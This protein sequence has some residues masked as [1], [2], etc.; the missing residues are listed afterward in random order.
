[1]EGVNIKDYSLKSLRSKVG[2][3]YQDALFVDGGIREYRI[4]Y[5]S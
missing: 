1:M 3:M 2:I 4:Y 5:F